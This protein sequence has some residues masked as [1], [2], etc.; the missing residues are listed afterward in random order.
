MKTES[1]VIIGTGRLACG[2]LEACLARSLPVRCVE[3][4]KL[5]FS[6]LGALCRKRGVSYEMILERDRLA[7]LFLSITAPTLVVSAFNYFIFPKAVLENGA[8]NVINYHP[9]LLPRHRG[10]NGPSWSIYEMEPVAGMT[11]HEARSPVDTGD[12]IVQ[13]SIQ[14][15][16]DMTALELAQETLNV[17]AEA[18]EEVL[19]SLVDGS[20]PR[21]PLPR[22]GEASFHRSTDVPNGGVLDLGWA[23]EKAYAFLRAMDYGK[24]RVFPPPRVGFLGTQ[25]EVAGYRM[26]RDCPSA[27]G[28]RSIAMLNKQMTMQGD[29]ARL[30]LNC[31]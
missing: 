20:Y 12:I 21:L 6:P 9:S 19:P 7:S 23:V 29:R 17:A 22:A 10:R 27:A 4:E 1:V 13:K 8:L 16:Q 11:W 24:F 5:V 3:S 14:I 25:A 15:G 18:F 2:C 30:L 28:G 31:Q 26:Q